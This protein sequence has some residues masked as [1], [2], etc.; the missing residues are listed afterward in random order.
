MLVIMVY[1]RTRVW[2][3]KINFK[4]V[5]F[6]VQWFLNAPKDTRWSIM[7]KLKFRI[8]S[9][10][11]DRSTSD[12]CWWDRPRMNPWGHRSGIGLKIGIISFQT[13][14]ELFNL[15]CPNQYGHKLRNRFGTDYGTVPC[16]KGCPGICWGLVFVLWEEVA[17]SVH[18][19][20]LL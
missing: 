13:M 1:K 16:P 8:S 20:E 14:P 17:C 5:Q 10:S 19:K 9:Q 4:L 11:C 2:Q 3:H 15:F 6:F 7:K 18:L 12:G